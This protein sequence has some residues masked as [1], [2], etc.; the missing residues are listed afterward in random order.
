MISVRPVIGLKTVLYQE[1]NVFV[2]QVTLIT[3]QLA[4]IHALCVVRFLPFV[5]SAIIVL[6]ALNVNRT[7]FFTIQELKHNAKLVTSIVRHAMEGQITAQVAM[8][9]HFSECL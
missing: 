6:Y 7:T 3:L 2:S 9:K 1:I 8:I 5:F 4:I